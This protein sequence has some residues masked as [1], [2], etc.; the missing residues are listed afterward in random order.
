VRPDADR[1]V[2]LLVR[3]KGAKDFKALQQL[4]TLPDGTWSK[5]ITPTTGASYRYEWTP[6]PTL[7]E[8]LPKPKLSGIVDLSKK[9]STVIHASSALTAA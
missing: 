3:P 1:K 6:K 8:P 5:Q 2:T 7:K 4:F 9:E